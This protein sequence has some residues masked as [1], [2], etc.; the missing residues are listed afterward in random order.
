[1]HNIDQKLIEEFYR[2]EYSDYS[3][4]I[5][6][7]INHIKNFNFKDSYYLELVLEYATENSI[8]TNPRSAGASIVILCCV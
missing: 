6:A 4:Y 5:T 2:M 8:N 1:M 3:T 7:Y